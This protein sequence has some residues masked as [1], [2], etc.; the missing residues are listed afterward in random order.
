M[1][2]LRFKDD[3]LL[4]FTLIGCPA[5]MT[6]VLNVF[7]D[8]G[9]HVSLTF[10]PMCQLANTWETSQVFDTWETSQVLNTC[11]QRMK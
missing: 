10:E 6:L 8:F 5:D 7:A 11:I 2:M 9:P 4:C 3:H 1:K